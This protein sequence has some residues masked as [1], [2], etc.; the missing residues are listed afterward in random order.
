[1]ISGL[2]NHDMCDKLFGH[3]IAYYLIPEEKKIISNMTLNMVQP[4]NILAIL[5]RIRPRNISNI[6]QVI[7]ICVLNNK[8]L[9]GDITK[10]Q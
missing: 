3:P 1:M 7:N 8:A 10:M 4:K 5:K 2:Y 9:N 6:K